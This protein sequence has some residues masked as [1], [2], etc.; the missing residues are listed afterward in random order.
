MTARASRP[1]ARSGTSRLGATRSTPAWTRPASSARTTA[2]LTWSHVAGLREHPSTPGWQPGAGGLI[3]HSIVPHPTDPARMWVGISAVGVFHTADGGA[4][5][6][7]RNRGV[8]AVGQPDEYPETGAVR[9]QVRPSSRPARG[10]LPAEPLGRLPLRRRW[11]SPGRT[12]TLACPRTSASG[13]P[14]TRTTRGR[15]GP[16]RSTATTRDASCPTAVPR[17]G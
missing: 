6:E 4:T 5:W 2:G 13:W 15:S 16:R 9:P 8:R 1:S 12:S 7:A 17:S 14:S 3:L 10:P 11:S